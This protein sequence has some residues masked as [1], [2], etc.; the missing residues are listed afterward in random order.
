[1]QKKIKKTIR[2]LAR[3]TTASVLSAPFLAGMAT[4]A[5]VA[6]G[7]NALVNPMC[8]LVTLTKPAWLTE[9]SITV[10]ES[11]DDNVFIA[12]AKPSDYKTVNLNLVPSSIA[13]ALENKSCFVTAVS[14]KVGVNFA[15][16]LGD[17]HLLQTLS[18][19]YAA[20]IVN[21]GSASTEN[22]DAH[23]IIAAINGKTDD[24]SFSAENTFSAIDGSKLG[25]FYPGA[26]AS[27]ISIGILRERRDQLQDRS[28]VSLQY[29]VDKLFIRPTGYFQ[30][31]DLQTE[32]LS[33]A[34][35]GGQ[36]GYQNYSDR[37][38]V[39]GGLDLGYR[40]M[41]AFA[42]TLGYRYGAQ[43]QETFAKSIDPVG[44]SAS[45][46]YQRILVGFEGK[47]IQWLDAKFQ[48]GPDFRDYGSKAP[49]SD[50][51][52]VTYYGEASL[53]AT[54]SSKDS[55][56]FN[57]KQFQWVSSIGKSP[58]FDS[59]FD[60]N[61]KR[62]LTDQLSMDLGAR[63]VEADYTSGLDTTKPVGTQA[64]FKRDDTMTTMSV[65]LTYTFNA[66]ASV[67]L[68]YSLDLGRNAEDGIVNPGTR[69]FNRNVV[70][71]A[72]RFSF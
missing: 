23:R 50:P 31:Y 70:S 8:P 51:H 49:V 39:N 64:L 55:L 35:V 28:V 14:P 27:A 22:Y 57:Y 6:T 67:S 17:Q 68:A 63:V 72:A 60:L 46:D 30:D 40:I 19:G 66:H 15:P 58:Y 62:K 33:K 42:A 3:F 48:I 13:L 25:P 2:S 24:V 41:P 43:Y 37:Y 61:Y 11:Y 69:E 9:L 4:A 45:S 7:S 5:D 10:K 21:Y 65:G 38:D 32:Q 26:L 56:S 29:D 44:F 54:I 20:D 16:L 36:A 59:A 1:M 52:M 53:T 18:L 34:Q 12:G 47:P 71:A